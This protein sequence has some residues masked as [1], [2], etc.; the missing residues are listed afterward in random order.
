MRL[1]MCPFTAPVLYAVAL[2]G[3]GGCSSPP[4]CLPH[5]QEQPAWGRQTRPGGS[6][7]SLSSLTGCSRPGLGAQSRSWR[8]DRAPGSIS[9]QTSKQLLLTSDAEQDPRLKAPGPQ[10]GGARLRPF[11]RSGSISVFIFYFYC[12]WKR[13]HTSHAPRYP[14]LAGGFRRRRSPCPARGR[15]ASCGTAAGRSSPANLQALPPAPS[16]QGPPEPGLKAPG[17]PSLSR[18]EKSGAGAGA[19]RLAAEVRA[20]PHAGDR[21]TGADGSGRRRRRRSGGGGGHKAASRSTTGAGPGARACPPA[22][23]PLDPAARPAPAPAA[24]PPPPASRPTVSGHTLPRRAPAGTPPPPARTRPRRAGRPM[25]P[26]YGRP[27][28]ARAPAPASSRPRGKGEGR[29]PGGREAPVREG[30]F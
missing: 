22:D 26:R 27:P 30:A 25:S 21:S 10:R 19:R 12:P 23:L 6:G 9:P 29:R 8:R 15:A 24:R 7:P 17:P 13:A 3:G 5:I 4:S 2:G 20:A 28:P 14:R 1:E 11:R 16:P 18:K